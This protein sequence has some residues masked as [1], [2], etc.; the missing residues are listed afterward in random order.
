MHRVHFRK[1]QMHRPEAD[2][3]SQSEFD[4]AIEASYKPGRF[5]DTTGKGHLDTSDWAEAHRTPRIRDEFVW[6]K[7]VTTES[8]HSARDHRAAMCRAAQQGLHCLLENEAD[9]LQDT[10]QQQYD[11]AYER[12]LVLRVELVGLEQTQAEWDKCCDEV[13]R[14]AVL[15]RRVFAGKLHPMAG[16]SNR[17]VS[18]KEVD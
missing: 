14:P 7:E 5:A 18:K 15:P 17:K 11:S 12:A 2:Y 8:L 1:D 16:Q 10:L 6:L 3:R 13:L 4:R 9:A